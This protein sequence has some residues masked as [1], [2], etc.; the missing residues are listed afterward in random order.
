M[1]DLLCL[2]Q[3]KGLHIV[4][5]KEDENGVLIMAESRHEEQAWP[6]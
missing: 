3:I 5:V 2:P 4:E 1:P 6:N